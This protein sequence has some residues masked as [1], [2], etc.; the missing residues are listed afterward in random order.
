M[1][2]CHCCGRFMT[3]QSGAAWKMVYSGHPPTP[4][5]EIYKCKRCVE[6]EGP[7]EPQTGIRPEMS[8]GICQ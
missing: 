7:F 5:C 8:C 2:K 1:L 3:Y 6:A 4:D